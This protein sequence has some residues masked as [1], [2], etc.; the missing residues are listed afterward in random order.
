MVPQRYCEV[1]VTTEFFHAGG[2]VRGRHGQVR[3]IAPVETID[4]AV[5]SSSRV[6]SRPVVVL[7][8]PDS[9]AQF[10][11]N[12]KQRQTDPGTIRPIV[13]SDQGPAWT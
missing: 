3:D 1:G 2:R 10:D 8:Q 7:P 12:I 9:K 4:P 6:S 5:G 11:Q 13:A